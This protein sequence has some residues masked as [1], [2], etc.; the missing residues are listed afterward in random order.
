M[1]NLKITSSI[2]DT[3]VRKCGEKIK[4]QSF[5]CSRALISELEFS[6]EINV[7]GIK[8]NQISKDIKRSENF[9]AIWI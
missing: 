8:I 4:G 2:D 1:L 3:L 9:L 7:W 6:L 5:S